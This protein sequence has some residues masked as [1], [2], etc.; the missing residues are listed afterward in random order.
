M[1]EAPHNRPARPVLTGTKWPSTPR[2]GIAIDG[3]A[4]RE[5]GKPRLRA[6]FEI[7]HPISLLRKMNCGCRSAGGLNSIADGPGM[8]VEM[9]IYANFAFAI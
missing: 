6:F 8:A 5:Q 4:A 2:L 9:L 7:L 1:T 3:A